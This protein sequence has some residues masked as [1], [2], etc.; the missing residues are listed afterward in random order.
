MQFILHI[1]FPKFTEY[2][3]NAP[4][5]DDAAN[6]SDSHPKDTEEEKHLRFVTFKLMA[7]RLK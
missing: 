5:S 3:N 1:L 6:S 7:R 2:E 4:W